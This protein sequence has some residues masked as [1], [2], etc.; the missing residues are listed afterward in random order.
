M[1]GSLYQRKVHPVSQPNTT[2]QPAEV[3]AETE[4]A[5]MEESADQRDGSWHPPVKKKHFD[6]PPQP[7]TE[8]QAPTDAVPGTTKARGRVGRPRK[9]EN[10]GD[11]RAYLTV[12]IDKALHERISIMSV[13]SGESLKSI[14]ETWIRTYTPEA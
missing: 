8:I 13:R 11:N 3:S 9:P 5:A 4:E 12:R 2:P 10:F 7:A 6:S 1:V 14:V